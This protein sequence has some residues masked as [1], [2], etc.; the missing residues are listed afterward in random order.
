M[1]S[2]PSLSQP[3]NDVVFS[4]MYKASLGIRWESFCYW[5]DNIAFACRQSSNVQWDVSSSIAL[6]VTNKL[7]GIGRFGKWWHCKQE[8]DKDTDPSHNN[9][10]ITYILEPFT[11]KTISISSRQNKLF[12]CNE[13]LACLLIWNIYVEEKQ[14]IS[15]DSKR[16]S[17][18]QAVSVY[19]S[20]CDKL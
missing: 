6:L 2:S 4:R 17:Y 16:F 5:D 20:L 11:E 3:D 14:I 12:I 10:T 13:M 8:G 7:T 9:R 18:I 15:H 1:V 19:S